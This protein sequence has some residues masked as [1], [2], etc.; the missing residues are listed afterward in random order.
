MI[1]RTLIFI[2]LISC[3]AACSDHKAH[4][5][6]SA[7]INFR[8]SYASLAN[9]PDPIELREDTIPGLDWIEPSE[10]SSIVN[11][12]TDLGLVDSN[13]FIIQKATSLAKD[14]VFANLANGEKVKFY[15]EYNINP[16]T[17]VVQIEQGSSNDTIQIERM[18]LEPRLFY[19][20]AFKK[21]G[22]RLVVFDQWYFMNGDMYTLRVFEIK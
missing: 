17:Q 7:S 4:L 16:D 22:K 5:K 19:F 14:T 9:I 2:A 10:D 18:S 21:Y 11:Y 3:T 8:R 6:E 12:L 1:P 20:D 15:L 13:K